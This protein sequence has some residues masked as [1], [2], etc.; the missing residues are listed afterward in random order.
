MDITQLLSFCR[1]HNAS[2]LHLA[3]GQ[4]PAIRAQGTLKRLKSDALDSA[5][6][7]KILYAVMDETQ[8]KDF[9]ASKDIDFAVTYGE[10][11]RFRVN[12]F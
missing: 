11:A 4:V 6:V 7:K 1:D 8:R 5:Q 2:D 3:A 10:K 12:A 9:E